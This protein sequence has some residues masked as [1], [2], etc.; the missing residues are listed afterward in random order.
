[1]PVNPNNPIGP[2]KQEVEEPV[3]NPKGRTRKS[4]PTKK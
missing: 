3:K 4:K 1:M 2:K